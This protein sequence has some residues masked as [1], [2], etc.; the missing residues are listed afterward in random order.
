M[1]QSAKQSKRSKHVM[2]LIG[3]LNIKA[4]MGFSNHNNKQIYIN[5]LH[6]LNFE[7]LT[8]KDHST[9]V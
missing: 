5:I 6:S 4:H 2:V 7:R 1:A 9:K 8:I 3:F